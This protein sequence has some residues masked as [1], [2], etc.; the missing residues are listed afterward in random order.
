MAEGRPQ[1]SVAQCNATYVEIEEGGIIETPITSWTL[2]SSAYKEKATV[3]G[4][5]VDV[6][7]LGTSK[8]AGQAMIK[9]PAGTV[10]VSYTA[11]AWN[12]KQATLLFK[13]GTTTVHSQKLTANSGAANNSP[14]TMTV[15]STD[16]YE[17]EYAVDAEAFLTLDTTNSTSGNQRALIWNIVAYVQN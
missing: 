9:L 16:T 15:K 5:S 7:K 2:V 17:F 8:L 10:K 4:V 12:G 14:Y 11:V 3:N 6:L 13:N 1:S